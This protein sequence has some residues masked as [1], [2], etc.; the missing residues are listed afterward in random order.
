MMVNTK[1][2]EPAHAGVFSK[3]TASS[4]TAVGATAGALA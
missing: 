2:R 3:I 1:G 4:Y